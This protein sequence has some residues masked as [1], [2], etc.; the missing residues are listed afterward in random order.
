MKRDLIFT[1]LKRGIVTGLYA[2]GEKLPTE[3]ELSARYGVARGTVR[4]SLKRLEEAGYL[5]RVK[6]K[7]TFIRQPLHSSN[8]D[9]VI[10]FLIP[11]PSYIRMCSDV[12]FLHF[13]QALYGAIRAA[14]ENGWRVETVPFSRTNNNSDIDW[15]A[16]DHIREDSR[17]IIFNHWYYPAFETFLKRRVRVGIIRT[18]H[19]VKSPWDHCFANWIDAVIDTKKKGFDAVCFLYSAGCRKILNACGY[20]QDPYNEKRLGYREGIEYTG[21]ERLE[22]DCDVFPVD[23]AG[24]AKQ[25]VQTIHDIWEK[26]HFDALIAD[27]P[28]RFLTAGGNIY[29]TLGIPQSVKILLEKDDPAA[30]LR[31]SPQISAFHV[32]MDWIGYTVAKRLMEPVYQPCQIIFN[33]ILNNRESSGGARISLDD[34]PGIMETRETCFAMI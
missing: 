13:S 27:D 3:L 11:Y 24:S 6:S 5:E 2:P 26:T 8:E 30:Y 21:L 7:G 9:K 10:S 33:G 23:V 14:S 18:F 22:F 25:I 19:H 4:E 34:P 20:Y 15:Q 28:H 12:T 17:L 29:R 16:L 32:D 1:E 31:T